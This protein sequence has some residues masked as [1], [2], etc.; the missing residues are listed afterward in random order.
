MSN[1]SF[2]S[3]IR[4]LSY[5]KRYSTHTVTAYQNDLLQFET[6]LK[7]QYSISKLH[8]AEHTMIR[9]WLVHLMEHEGREQNKKME[10]RSVNR[11]ISALRTFYHF[12]LK[13]KKIKHDPMLK[14]IRP[15]EAKKLP[16]FLDESRTEMLLDKADFGEGFPAQ[17]DRLVLEMLYAT[18]MRVSELCNITDQ[19][20]NMSECTVKVLGK[21]NKERIIPFTNVMK[22]LISAYRSEKKKCGLN[23]DYFF[24]TDDGKKTY[25]KFVYRLTNKYLSI[26]STANKKSP[27]VMRHTFATHM[28]NAGADINSIK[29]ILGHASLAATQVYTHNTIEKLKKV[30]KQAHP[31]A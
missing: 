24:V 5:E 1:M 23:A 29:E 3:F 21:R 15:K 14:I 9:S 31:R 30:Y 16:V 6:F 19:S 17:R 20:I 10:A 8:E 18:G 26:V 25:S 22:D 11:K 27:H 12:L 13:N 4:Y 28:L 2:D 7:E